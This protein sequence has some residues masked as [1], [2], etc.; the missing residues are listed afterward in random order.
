LPWPVSVVAAPW[1]LLTFLIL[2]LLYMDLVNRLERKPDLRG[3]PES[4]RFEGW[5]VR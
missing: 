5:D 2:L 4:F 3:L 1:A